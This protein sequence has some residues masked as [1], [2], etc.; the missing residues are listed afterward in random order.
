MKKAALPGDLMA[1]SSEAI[2]GQPQS[3]AVLDIDSVCLGHCV[4]AKSGEQ[5]QATP[6]DSSESVASSGDETEKGDL[7][8]LSM[9]MLQ[10]EH[11]ES[12]LQPVGTEADNTRLGLDS[13]QPKAW[14]KMPAGALT[15]LHEMDL[16]LLAVGADKERKAPARLRD[17]ALLFGWPTAKHSVRD[18][19]GS[20]PRV[21]ACGT[22]TGKDAHG[23]AVFD[24]DGA[25]ARGWLLERGC[26]PTT[27]TTWQI[28]RNTDPERL[29]VAFRLDPE[30][31]QQ[32]GQIHTKVDTKPPALDAN[33]KEIT[34]GEAVE[35]FHG[36][37]QVIV[38]GEHWLSK[39]VYFW[40]DDM[41]PEA[42][43][44][45]PPGWWAA[46]LEITSSKATSSKAKAT[47]SNSKDWM[48][49]N[50]CPICGRDSTG[51]CSKH[52]D[53]A[54]IRCFHGS[55]FN[56]EHNHGA[57][58]PGAE[59]TDRQG[60]IWA[61]AKT[62]A[63][64]NGDVFSVFV[65]PKP[66]QAKTAKTPPPRTG[67]P[68]VD[69]GTS[70]AKPA[71]F[72]A[73]IQQLPDG[74]RVS[75]KTG[76]ATKGSMSAGELAEKLP[77]VWLRFNEMTLRG[78][79]ST[80]NGWVQIT[81]ADMDS[82]YVVLTGKGWKVGLD[83]TVKAVLHVARQAPHHPVRDYLRRLEADPTV[84]PFDLDKVAK[85]FFRA[86]SD[87]HAEMVR[88]W[89]I[90]AVARA[91]EPGCKMDYCLVFKGG[92][93]QKKSWTLETLGSPEWHCSSIPE[94]EKDLLLNVH[95]TWIYELAELESV[96]GRKEAGR[97]KNLITTR[98]DLVRVPYGRTSERMPRQSVFC[99]T[100]NEDTFLR[101]D[102]GNRRY[103]VVPVEGGEP[104]DREGLLAARDGIW[105]A[106]VAAYRAGALPVL[107]AEMELL[108][109]Q[110]NEDFNAQDPWVEMVRAWMAGDPMHRWDPDRD[111]STVIYSPDRPVAT[112]D[113]IYSAGLRRPDQIGK[114]D[115]MRAAAVL[116]QLGFKQGKQQRVDGRAMRLWE[117]SQPSRP[118]TTSKARG[119]DTQ[120]PCAAMDLGLPSQPS[121][122][123]TM[124]KVA[125]VE[126]TAASPTTAAHI[127]PLLGKQV[128]TVVTPPKPVAAQSVCLSQPPETEVVTPPEVVT[129]RQA[130]DA[131][132]RELKPATDLSGWSD[133]ELP[134]LLQS[135]EAA[136]TR[137]AAATGIAIP[138]VA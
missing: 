25:T 120:S 99:A 92:Q 39:G 104:L 128:V 85:T 32:I 62:E 10:A 5:S 108:S 121:Q 40:P 72:Q 80:T 117:P 100:V 35:L 53:G 48:P 137:R 19:E 89:L 14:R 76:A 98:A 103:W 4:T 37:G 9:Q 30:Q 51:Y 135:L 115:Q 66:R 129:P 126:T 69:P 123:K 122:P 11:G 41:G 70:T 81:D 21:I 43:A 73:L 65:T 50:P 1:K 34:K 8:L 15:R 36:S 57:L 109:A 136:H 107:S 38:L 61:L 31:Q 2:L 49:L 106:A 44:E 46:A 94:G 33:G 29:K 68:L 13:F 133:E 20:S 67:T 47:S 116:R 42:L 75:E 84:A 83:P 74:W 130:I 18:I 118:V 88:K 96:T 45:I 63:Q 16:P 23:L 101:D 58:K 124:E 54:T 90:G 125:E 138:E 28:H 91:L 55:T 86:Q 114:A 6:E 132:L 95:S 112:A 24:I 7:S 56:P 134:E 78:E 105:K 131:R 111:P 127:H 22:R 71:S 27:T 77:S 97:L 119:C 52:R 93:G 26:E 102:T 64:A 12:K 82:A 87:L 59:I 110:Q 79:V 3:Q 17:G 60:T 113:V